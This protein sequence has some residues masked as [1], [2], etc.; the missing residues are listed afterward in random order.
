MPKPIDMME[1]GPKRTEEMT[2][3][4]LWRITVT[5]PAFAQEARHDDVDNW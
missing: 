4:G 5:P 3:G 1:M 2:E